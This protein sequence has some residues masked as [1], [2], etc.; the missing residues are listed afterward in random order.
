MSTDQGE[1]Q[2]KKTEVALTFGEERVRTYFNPH[3]SPAI[4]QIKEKT[5]AVMDLLQKLHEK[6]DCDPRLVALAQTSYEQAA[7]WAVK[8]VTS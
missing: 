6:H 5:A 1:S 2:P 8:A 4:S 7:M 3:E